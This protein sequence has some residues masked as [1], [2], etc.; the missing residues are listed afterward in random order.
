[1]RTVVNCDTDF[2]AKLIQGRLENEGIPSVVLNE[3][4]NVV[5]PAPS[6][7]TMFAVQVAVSD[8]DYEK[9]LRIIES[10]DI[11][12]VIDANADWDIENE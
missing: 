3:Y 11:D 2:Q 1:M 10:I 4:I 5:V 12:A 9:A 8:E 7:S 6:A